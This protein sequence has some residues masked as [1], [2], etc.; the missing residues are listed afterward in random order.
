MFAL[1][2]LTRQALQAQAPLHAA[3]EPGVIIPNRAATLSLD[4]NEER[5][6]LHLFD[7][8]PGKAGI[9]NIC[10]EMIATVPDHSERLLDFGAAAKKGKRALVSSGA[11]TPGIDA[12]FSHVDFRE[13]GITCRL[14]TNAKAPHERTHM[15]SYQRVTGRFFTR[16]RVRW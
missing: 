15:T 6:G 2:I 8:Q 12:A 13:L 16:S 11:L 9:A 4:L 5:L 7:D 10:D 3:G 14:R 1:I